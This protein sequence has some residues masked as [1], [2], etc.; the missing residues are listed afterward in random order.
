MKPVEPTVTLRVPALA[1]YVDLV[2]LTLYGIASKLGFLYEEI[3]D[4]KVAVSEACN[5]AVLHAY[6]HAGMMEIRFLIMDGALSISVKD[7]G[8]S[9]DPAPE[10]QTSPSLHGKTLDEIEAGGL[11]LYLMQ[12]LMDEVEVLSGVGTEV[13]LT[14]RLARSEEMA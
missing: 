14:K 10:T 7:E 13:V 8:R 1:E 9:F 4:M 6:E 3:E 2:R 5:N 11:G 12:A